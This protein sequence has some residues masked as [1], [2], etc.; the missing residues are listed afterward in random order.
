MNQKDKCGL[1]AL[2]HALR[3][4]HRGCV[5]ILMDAGA[6]VNIKGPRTSEL[7]TAAL[8][9][10]HDRI[11]SLLIDAGT[12]VNDWFEYIDHNDGT[13]NPLICV[14]KKGAWS[15][16]HNKYMRSIKCVKLLLKAGVHVNKKFMRHNALTWYCYQN[17]HPD[18]I[19]IK[20]LYAAGEVVEWPELEHWAAGCVFIPEW[21][22]EMEVRRL[23]LKD[24]CRVLIRTYLLRNDLH[25]NLFIRVPKLGL[26][27]PLTRYLLYDMTLDISCTEED[28]GTEYRN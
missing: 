13:N 4:R 21:L 12:D 18:E 8:K 9:T 1:I 25:T 10:G 6:D 27:A 16:E 20:L 28:I 26:P 23:C 7:L 14:A 22:Q 17:S 2:W 11:V 5:D 3:G 24:Q 19:F 15:A